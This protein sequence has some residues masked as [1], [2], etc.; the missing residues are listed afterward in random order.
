M[1]NTRSSLRRRDLSK[2]TGEW[3]ARSAAER[4]FQETQSPYKVVV[5]QAALVVGCPLLRGARCLRVF[6]DVATWACVNA[7]RDSVCDHVPCCVGMP[8]G[9]GLA[10]QS[11]CLPASIY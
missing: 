3:A 7:A 1:P 8:A 11:F 9:N 5:P 6:G 4:S 2:L 10:A